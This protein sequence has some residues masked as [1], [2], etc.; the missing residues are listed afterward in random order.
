MT[1]TY[2]EIGRRIVEHEQKGS[3]KAEYGQRLLDQLAKDLTKRLGR[4]FS[5]TNLFQMR[6]FFLSHR[7][8][9]QTVSGL[10][11]A[12]GKSQTTSGQFIP[13]QFFPLSW[14]HYVRLLSVKSDQAR[15]FYEEEALRGG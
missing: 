2:W 6:Q 12:S 5:R 8:I 9:I 7:E 11:D 3:Q 13:G 10:F 14:S 1:V 15:R 4:G